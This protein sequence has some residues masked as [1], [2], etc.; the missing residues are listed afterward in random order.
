MTGTVRPSVGRRQ[1]HEG[2]ART[3]S[4]TPASDDQR[5]HQP[6][7]SSMAAADVP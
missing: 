7:V 4:R 5:D 1:W 6:G 2:L 3:V